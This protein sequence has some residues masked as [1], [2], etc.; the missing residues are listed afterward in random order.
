MNPTG[1]PLPAS[2]AAMPPSLL[3]S[4]ADTPQWEETL[5]DG[6]RVLIRR[7][8]GTDAEL[9]RRFIRGLSPESRRLRFLA[10]FSEPSEELIRNLTQLPAGDVA[11]IALVHRDGEKK[12]VGASRYSVLAD[13]SGSECAVVV[14]D[15]WRDK[16]L[17]TIL[18]RHLIETARQH[19]LR[20]MVSTDAAGNWCMHEL[21]DDLGFT[22]QPDPGDSRQVLYRLVL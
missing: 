20:S 1:T 15:Q 3:P 13:G 12:V 10:Q 6:S 5:R 2:S 4:P 16:G 21:A 17:G 22:C 19:G 9:E 18:M 14:D 11:F 7:L 8:R